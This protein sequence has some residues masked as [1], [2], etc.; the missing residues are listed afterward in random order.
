MRESKLLPPPLKVE[1][2][3]SS[4]VSHPPILRSLRLHWANEGATRAFAQALA[5]ACAGAVAPGEG[6][7]AFVELRGDLGAG[8]TTLVRH[9]LRALG[10]QGRIK[11]PTYAVVETYVVTLSGRDTLS[12]S[13]FDFYRFDDPNEW[14]EAGFRDVFAAPGLKLAEWPEKV[15]GASVSLPVC[16]L[17]LH[18]RSAPDATARTN[19]GNDAD[20]LDTPR[21]VACTVYTPTGLHLLAAAER[22]LFNTNPAPTEQVI[23]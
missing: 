1:S 23:G 22:H 7:Q 5:R 21:E 11:S 16:D 6:I 12:V 10:V 14:E 15:R 13:H 18:L 3:L 17:A 2:K 20:T 4:L 9:L 19:T 8:K